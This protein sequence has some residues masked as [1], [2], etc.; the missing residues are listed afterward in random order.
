[1]LSLIFALCDL[2]VIYYP[3][4]S[5]FKKLLPPISFLLPFFF[6]HY[7]D[8]D[9]CSFFGET[10]RAVTMKLIRYSM[11][12][13]TFPI[14]TFYFL[15]YVVFHGDQDMLGWSGMGA[16]IAANIVIAMYV[17]MAWNEDK[18]DT[19]SCVKQRVD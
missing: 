5:F 10:N 17:V 11:L 15:F 4:V 8:F 14:V 7:I 3:F 19:K 2:V 16:V 6:I 1:M 18:G 9:F 12:M 13:F